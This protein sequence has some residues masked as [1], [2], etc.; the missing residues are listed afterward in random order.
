MTTSASTDTTNTQPTHREVLAKDVPRPPW[1][2]AIIIAEYDEDD[3]DMM[4][5]YFNHRTTR[6][7]VLAWSKHTR[8]LFSEMRKAATRFPATTHLG[9]GCGRFRPVVVLATDATDY[10]TAYC[11]GTR[12]PWHRRMYEDE[13]GHAREFTT[14]TAARAFTGEAGTPGPIGL[15]GGESATSFEWRI[16]SE[17]IEHREKHSLGAGYYLKVG[18]DNSTG[19]RV[20]KYRLWWLGTNRRIEDHVGGDAR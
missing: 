10:G 11:K 5:D 17:S 14:Q 16:E 8:D 9:P 6:T 4:S 3:C 18:S 20:Q 13:H 19:W 2:Q 7:V 12:S 1:A 15:S